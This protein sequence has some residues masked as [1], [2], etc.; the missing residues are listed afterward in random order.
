M[1]KFCD[2]QSRNELADFLKIPRKKLSY[3]LYVVTPEKCYHTFEIPKKSGGTRTI[4]APNSDLKYV[5]KMLANALYAYQEEYR[6]SEGILQKVSHAFEKKKSIV[7]NAK[8]H[9]NKRYVLNVDLEDYFGS[10]HI[11][12]VIGYFENN[13]HFRLNHE[14]SVT[15]AKIACYQ[16]NCHR[17]QHVPQ[18][19]QI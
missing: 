18:L 15:I 8:I 14:V 12:R 2:I 16:G 3:I 9:R 10:F 13:R 11:G 6:E 4:D 1:G 5:Q 17:V 19:L 7:T